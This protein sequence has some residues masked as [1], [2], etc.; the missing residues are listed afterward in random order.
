MAH[1]HIGTQNDFGFQIRRIEWT[2]KEAV[3]LRHLQVRWVYILGLVVLAVD[4][5]FCRILFQGV[6][7]VRQLIGY[8]ISG[9]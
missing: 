4:L 5:C 1:I 3:S 7:E 8:I 6:K 9:N 2:E